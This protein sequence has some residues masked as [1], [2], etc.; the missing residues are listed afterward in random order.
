VAKVE[1]FKHKRQT[2]SH[3]ASGRNSSWDRLRRIAEGTLSGRAELAVTLGEAM[4]KLESVE[5]AYN[6]AKKMAADLSRACLVVQHAHH[7][8]TLA[9]KIC[10]DVR[11][12]SA[13]R[14]VLGL[15]GGGGG[16]VDM[17]RKVQYRDGV[18]MA[19][20]AQICLNEMYRVMQ[21]YE[22]M[23]PADRMKDYEALKKL[24]LMQM[25]K[26]YNLMWGG[27]FLGDGV[28]G[29]VKLVLERQEAAFAHLTPL[30]VWIQDREP[31]CFMEERLTEKLRDDV[32]RE[33]A[34]VWDADISIR[35][36]P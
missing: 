13:G 23:L 16:I 19:S 6:A 5:N 9:L 36:R 25:S 24:G 33:V 7:Y 29:S 21:P 30:A 31:V 10:D 2:L 8:F 11:G 35:G 4:E 1:E 28:A 12:T 32:R 18:T 14:G 15:L 34:A 22:Y 26:I 27:S 20:K 3:I 17:T